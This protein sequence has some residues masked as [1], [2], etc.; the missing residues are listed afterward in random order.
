MNSLKR[1]TISIVLLAE[2]LCAIAFSSAALLHE[3]RTRLRAFDVMIQGRSDS[4]LGAIQ[5]AEDPEANVT[6]DP[7][8]LRVS[9]EDVYAVYNLGGRLLGT[10]KNAPAE[11]TQ[12]QGN[13][14]RNVDVNGH[15]YRVFQRSAIRV[16]DRV[17]NGGVGLQR[18]VTILF[19]A[20]IAHLWHEIVEAASFY[21]LVS[22]FLLAVTAGLMIVLLRRVLQPIQELAAQAASVSMSSL[23]FEAPR[24]ALALSELQPLAE[25]LSKTIE[26]L[27]EAFEK[28]H[29]FVSDAAHEL[30][31][32]VAVVR[33]TIQVLM[34]KSRSRVEYAEGLERLLADN[35]RV[36]ELVSQ[37]LMLARH[38]EGT[39]LDPV[40]T[41]IARSVHRALENLRSFAEEHTVELIP[42]IATDVA[43]HL[44]LDQA[45]TLV[46]NLVVNAVQHSD[47]G[48]RVEVSLVRREQSAVLRVRDEGTGISTEAQPH[49]FE[50][51]YRED[52]SRSRETGGAGLGL[53]ICKSIVDN[54]GGSISID[55]TKGSGTTVTAVFSLA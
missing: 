49:V 44:S 43:V 47:R 46:S 16:I 48:S 2:L 31:T 52:T 32:A 18:P 9:P 41:D 4:L 3:R 35:S 23:H 25:T 19:A 10:S 8:E 11:L 17:E 53:A 37:M 33:S 34:L 45:E 51:F 28:E 39:R 7:A 24:S 42:E 1:R 14:F 54:A 30:K 20:P 13:G 27:R 22:I 21:L 50:R 26:S 40:A 38:E 55:S 6:I 15:G 5:D 36:E 12:R 29:R